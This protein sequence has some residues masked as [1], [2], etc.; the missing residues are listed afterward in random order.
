MKGLFLFITLIASSMVQAASHDH[1]SVHG[2]LIVGKSKVYLSHLPMFHSPHDYQVLIE[3]E[4]SAD[5]QTAYQE[6]LKSPFETL[7]TLVPETFVLPEMAQN[8]KPFKAQIYKGH[9]E[10]GGQE[11][12]NNVTVTIKKVL[13]FKKFVPNATKPEMSTLLLFGNEIEQF[14]A[15]QITAK[16]DFDQVMEVKLPNGS[17]FM[18]DLGVAEVPLNYSNFPL[19]PTSIQHA[20]ISLS[21]GPLKIVLDVGNQIYLE[22]GDLAH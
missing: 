6:A 5:G 18:K 21:Q 16:P 8:P 14:I 20:D 13:Y 3:A 22:H 12:A 7:F 2:M 9:F 1:P 17:G 11:I 10:R 15:H 19:R 4:F